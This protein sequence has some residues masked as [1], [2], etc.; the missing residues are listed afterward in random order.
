MGHVLDAEP[1]SVENAL[2]ARKI[3]L[4]LIPNPNSYVE[5]E[6]AWHSRKRTGVEFAQVAPQL[7][8]GIVANVGL[9]FH[10]FA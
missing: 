6:N 5:I 3:Q 9:T 2:P 4:G 8:A 10:N 7:L 1:K